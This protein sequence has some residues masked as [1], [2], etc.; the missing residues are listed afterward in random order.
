MSSNSAAA[1][2]NGDQIWAS[3]TNTVVLSF[4]A[5]TNILP[6]TSGNVVTSNVTATTSTIA[7]AFSVVSSNVFSLYA[8]TKISSDMYTSNSSILHSTGANRLIPSSNNYLVTGN[9][10]PKWLEVNRPIS[11]LDRSGQVV[12]KQ[13]WIG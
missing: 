12:A 8:N 9:T 11:T 3:T 4:T 2:S 10:E 13:V 7:N 6:L 1:F 5:N